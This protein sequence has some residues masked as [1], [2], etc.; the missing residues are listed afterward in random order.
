MNNM[1]YEKIL[2]NINNVKLTDHVRG[3]MKSFGKYRTV[4]MQLC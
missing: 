1:Y 4:Y 3:L 2:E